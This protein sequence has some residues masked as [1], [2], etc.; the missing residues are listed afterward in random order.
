MGQTTVRR[1]KTGTRVTKRIKT[2]NTTVTK[3]YGAGKK[4]KTTISTKVGKT[5]FT[6]S[7]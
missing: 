2:G 5:T 7:Y 6:R 3:T 1:T 4:T